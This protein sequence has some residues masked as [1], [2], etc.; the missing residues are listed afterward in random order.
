MAR[1][2]QVPASNTSP[3][4]YYRAAARKGA[5][6][7]ARS[8]SVR[9]GDRLLAA[10]LAPLRLLDLDE[11]RHGL[12]LRGERPRFGVVAHAAT[13]YRVPSSGQI[14]ASPSRLTTRWPRSSTTGWSLSDNSGHFWILAR[15][16]C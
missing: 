7:G 5:L 10:D 14:T 8:S 1:C 6:I 9:L 13:G 16:E 2:C 12:G 3:S 4:K 11:H 15:V